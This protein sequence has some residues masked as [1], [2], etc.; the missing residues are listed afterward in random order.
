M[1]KKIMTSAL[2]LGLLS[3]SL[4]SG[5]GAAEDRDVVSLRLM[6]TTDIHVNVM[7]Y[8][9]YKDAE[10]NSYGLAKTATLIR[11]A[12]DEVKNSLLFD[13]GDLIQGNP[14]G[15][16]VA[17][18]DVLEDGEIHPVYKAMNLLD[19]DAGNIGNH[20]FNYGLDF[21]EKS[22]KGSEF[23][24]TNA[25]V[26]EDDQDTDPNNDKNYFEPY[27]LLDRT[28]VDEDGEE[29]TIKV[30]V[31]GFVPPQIMQWDKAHL[32]DHVVAKDMVETAK[33]YVPE[34]KEKGA[35]II[36][37]IPHSGIGD[38]TNDGMEENAT[39]SL[40]KVEGIDALL[41]GHAHA[42]FPSDA[43]STIENVDIEKGTIN[44]VASVEPGFWGNSLGI[45]DLTIEN[46]NGKWEVIDGNSEVRSIVDEEGNPTVDVDQ[47]IVD[48]VSEDHQATVD[49]VR[50]AVGQL[51]APINSYFALVKDDPS[52][53]IVTNAQ[54]WYVEKYIKGTE[55]EGIPVLSAGAPFKA[56]GR[57]G[58]DYYTD[59][60]AGE[61]AIKNV[62]DL[63]LYPNTLQAVLINGSE[64]KEWLEM[65]AGQFNQIDPKKADEQQLINNEF[66]SY[67]YDVIDGITYQIDVAKPAKYNKDGE[68]VH[69]QSNRIVNLQFNGEP[70][71]ADQKFI[72]VTNNYRASGGGHFPGLDGSKTIIE[73]PDENRQVIINYI[74]EKGT[75]NPAADENWSF[76][77]VKGNPNVTFE[78]SPSA[79]AYAESIGA[80]SYVNTLDSGFAKYKLTLEDASNEV[81]EEQMTEDQ[82]EAAPIEE[83]T[84]SS[85]EGN[86]TDT[87]DTK[88]S[89]SGDTAIS[90]EKNK[91]PTYETYTVKAGDTLSHIGVKY[92]VE[93][94]E[95]AKINHLD[96]PHFILVGQVIKVPV[97]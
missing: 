90:E 9:Y 12:R 80:I 2:S 92:R 27:L 53:Q 59:V 38:M 73:S 58:A 29:H 13:N 8:D 51:E 54:K 52:I 72:V 16:Y 88:A 91:K 86:N 97:K 10:T 87:A 39:Y 63:Y 44:G 60:P 48:A 79:Q 68:I 19:Y 56:G 5:I 67:N 14:L 77:P 20:E 49:W 1:K 65:A 84:S 75:I 46:K 6:E 76:A 50:S 30:G 40:S 21:L 32:Q 83:Q 17:K 74:M 11:N 55:Y 95:L 42:V 61:I 47:Q 89:E 18:V 25:N 15:D 71:K 96:N 34:M 82:P 57:G 37:A 26:Y 33:K 78:T 3:S 41:F 28:V 43:F 45:V 66:P 69:A 70:V 4:L 94:K 93:W 23:P 24:Y 31:I 62:S 35:D 81:T 64:V 85:E 7:N 36:V 22:L